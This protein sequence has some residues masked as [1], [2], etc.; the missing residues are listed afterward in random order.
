MILICPKINVLV[1]QIQSNKTNA[2]FITKKLYA[3]CI[4]FFK[5]VQNNFNL[6]QLCN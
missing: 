5:R 1:R 3:Q 4:K 2:N 6:I